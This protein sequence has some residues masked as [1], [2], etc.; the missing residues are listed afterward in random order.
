[1]T[2]GRPSPTNDAQ[3]V[4]SGLTKRYRNVLAVNNLSFTVEPGRVTG[5][6]GPNGAGKT[7]TLRMLLNLVTPT[8][9]GATIGG[10]RYPELADPLRH[11]GAV[12][13]A[14]SAHKGRTGIN[15][16]RV[17][18][19]AA[20]LPRERADQ[21]LELVGLT[22]AAKRKFKGYSLGMKQRLGIAAAML[23]DP[24]VLILD[25]P[26]NGL[27]PEGIRWMRGFL[28]GL[29]TEGRTVLVSSH[30]LSE[31]QLLADDVVIIA[32]GQLVRQGPVEQVIGSMAQGV[33]VRVRTPQADALTAALK[34]G[35]ATVDSDGQGALLIGGVDAPTVGRA[36]LAAGVELHELTT[37]RPDLERVFLELTAGK[38]GIR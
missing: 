30:L 32:A 37:E 35:P 8:A 25:E 22:P 12:L 26:A 15:H 29:A 9:G 19:A 27:D 28:K 31:M 11:V 23:G 17:I 36:A 10:Q 3:I 20:G 2:D 38:A 7:T 24:R 5:F 6:L 33:R 14:S 1:M 34:D 21:A 13:E 16:L 18:C 4:V